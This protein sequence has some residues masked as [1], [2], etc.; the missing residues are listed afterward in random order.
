[1]STPLHTIFSWFETGDFP[2][3]AQF[4]ASWSSFWHKDDLVP[5]S[6]ISGLTQVIEQMASSEALQNHINDSNAHTGYLAKL[7]ASNLTTVNVNSWKEKLGVGEI[8]ANVALVDMGENQSV[9]NKDQITSICMLLENYVNSNGKIMS[10][11]IE[12]L[13][14]TQ[15]IPVS[16]FTLQDFIANHSTYDFQINDII[17]IPSS[18]PQQGYRLYFYN[19][20][21]KTSE[22]SYLATGLSNV[23]IAMVQGLQA[24]LDSNMN[25]PT[26]SGNY[27]ARHFLGQASWIAINPASSYLLFWN[28]NDF[29]GSGIYTDGTKFGIG[30]TVPAEAFH[31]NN[32]RLRTKAVVF[33]E[34][35]E[36][37]PYQITHKNR[38]YYGS[39]LTGA[40]YLFMYQTYADL[41]NLLLGLTD[42]QKE[43]IRND[44]RLTGEI[45][46]TGQPRIDSVILPFIDNSYTFTQY[47]TL[48]GLNLFV[49][50]QTPTANLIMK[51]V[52]DING[53]VLSTPEVYNITNFNV[54]Q[55]SP[56]TLNFGVKW[57]TY[58][59]GYYQFFCTHNHLTNPASPELLVK[60]GISFTT[61]NPVWQDLAG[62]ATVDSNNNIVLGSVGSARTNVLID[63]TQMVNGFVAKCSVST[64]VTN[65]GANFPGPTRFTLKGDD[66]LEYGVSLT[67]SLDFYPN[68]VGGFT[69]NVDV[70]YISYYNGILTLSA[71]VNG[72]TKI[73][74][75]TSIPTTPRYFYA[76][77]AGGGIG[78]FSAKPTQLLLL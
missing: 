76:S 49:D 35:T 27:Y 5:I 46:S 77:R 66:G 23:T 62:G 6:Q 70:I 21:N 57:N 54:L 47:V 42:P 29:I 13:G 1:M 22:D 11:M 71:E 60:K 50:N 48:I 4:Q 2:T 7:D 20:G 10:G 19:G 38:R 33:D 37:L 3:Q 16:E 15:L 45:Y 25:K 43:Q 44:L 55:S 41:H 9:F 52:K 56:N 53:S 14:L 74:A 28:G 24:A 65:N 78:S 39:D 34:N 40:Q 51:R 67:G 64:T 30:T 18:D 31:L 69:T 12:A 61:L 26:A 75:V 59:E 36:A 63:T 58:P 73:F 17:A 32:G 72:K 8:P 68:T